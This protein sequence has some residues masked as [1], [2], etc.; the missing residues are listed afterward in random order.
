MIFP[1]TQTETIIFDVKTDKE[2]SKV[3]NWLA[4]GMVVKQLH[5][6]T[7][8]LIRLSFLVHTLRIV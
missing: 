2:I 8:N 5:V 4:G 7:Y 6:V 1:L 3:Y